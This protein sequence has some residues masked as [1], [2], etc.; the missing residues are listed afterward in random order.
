M[1]GTITNAVATAPAATPNTTF[2]VRHRPLALPSI[3]YQPL[4][5]QRGASTDISI[6]HM[7]INLKLLSLVEWNSL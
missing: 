3:L 6:M 4:Q 7:Q 5:A 1:Y 2:C